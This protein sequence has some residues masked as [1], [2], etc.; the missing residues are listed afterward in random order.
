MNV[1]VFLYA[2]FGYT[3]PFSVTLLIVCLQDEILFIWFYL[4]LCYYV[5]DLLVFLFPA[6]CMF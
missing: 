6:A 5:L 2:S 3:H 1:M 4:A